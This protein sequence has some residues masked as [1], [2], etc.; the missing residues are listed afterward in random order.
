[1]Q[2]ELSFLAPMAERP[3][4]YMYPR[5]DGAPQHNCRFSEFAVEVRD[6]RSMECSLS[7]E[8]FEL[9]EA[10]SSVGDFADEEAVRTFYYAEVARLALDMTGARHAFVFDHQLRRREAGRAPLTFGRDD[11]GPRPGAAGR[12]HSDYTGASARRR[13]DALWQGSP[14][15]RFAILNV[16]RSIAGPVLDTPLAVCDARS[17]AAGDLVAADIHYP[18]RS[19][20]IHL[21]RHSPRQAWHYFDRMDR[22]EALVFKQYDSWEGAPRFVPHGAFDLPDIPAG[23]PLRESIEARCLV[24][25]D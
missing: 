16:W 5:P 8:G 20:E 23:A 1:M 17:V 10:R 19:G 7:R 6:A 14:S 15:R 12:V 3:W 9:R 11:A 2:A 22:H 21:V 4:H 13:L 25:Y 24:V 18:G